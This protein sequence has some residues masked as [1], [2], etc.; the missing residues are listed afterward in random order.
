MSALGLKL[1][2]PTSFHLK[3]MKITTRFSSRTRTKKINYPRQFGGTTL[4]AAIA[5]ILAVFSV[6]L[7]VDDRGVGRVIFLAPGYVYDGYVA[8]AVYRAIRLER[9]IVTP[10]WIVDH[11]YV[12]LAVV[13][14]VVGIFQLGVCDFERVSVVGRR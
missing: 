5:A 14:V 2:I 1:S 4:D 3:K 9:I 10:G 11:G 13:R 12:V 8:L 6:V 7:L